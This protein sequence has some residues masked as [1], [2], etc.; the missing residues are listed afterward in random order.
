MWT[1]NVQLFYVKGVMRYCERDDGCA[2]WDSGAV[3][4]LTS[5]GEGFESPFI[6][7]KLMVGEVIQPSPTL[8]RLSTKKGKRALLEKWRL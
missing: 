7:Q 4:E 1:D 5:L 2:W 6:I 8:S 3:M